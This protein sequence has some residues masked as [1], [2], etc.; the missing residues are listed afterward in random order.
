MTRRADR[1]FEIIQVLRRARGPLTAD[2]IATQLETSKRTIYRDVATLINRR[3]PIRGEAGT[4]YVLERGF[5]LPPLTL[6]HDEVWAVVLGMQWVSEHADSS[7]GD[8]AAKVLAKLAAVV[9]EG[10]RRLIDEPVVSTP[11]KRLRSI[12]ANVDL[13]KLRAW[14]QRGHKLE[15]TYRDATNRETNRTVWPFLLG[16]Q[17]GIKML[18]AWCE[19]RQDFRFFR[20]E[21]LVKVAFLDEPYPDRP[22]ALRE[23]WLAQLESELARL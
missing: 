22:A 13:G 15:V 6:T 21:R 23:R 17:D 16:Y 14:S 19:L 7:L 8:A 5:E 2:A 9:P 4:G 10:H 3:I 1:L 12:D 18:I 20:V 11:P